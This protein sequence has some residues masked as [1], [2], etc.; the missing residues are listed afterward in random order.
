MKIKKIHA[1]QILDSRGNP[2]IEADVILEDGSLGRAAVPSGA[3]TGKHEALELRDEDSTQHRGKGVLKAIENVNTIISNVLIGSD[4]GSQ[5]NIDQTL[6]SLDGTEN[7][8]RLGANAILAV[9][10]AYAQAVANYK[11]ISFFEYLAQVSG[12]DQQSYIMPVPLMNIINGGKHASFSTDIQEF[13]I[14]PI[15]AK[16]ISDALRMGTDVFHALAEVLSKR[17]YSTNVG[18]EGGYAPLVRKGNEEPLE[19]IS[20]AVK[21]AGLSLGKDIYLALDCAASEFYKNGKYSLKTEKL[22]LSSDEMISWFNKL[23]KSYPIISIEDGLDQEDW[24]GWVNLTKSLGDKI[25]IVGDDI[26]VTKLKFLQRGIDLKAA[27]AILIKLNQ[28]GTLTETIQAVK[29]A[30]E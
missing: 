16:S 30:K 11:K 14:L 25:Q 23:I 7:K 9:S 13:M 20:E 22:T 17:G 18:D 6:I 15:S 27:N 3:S 26:F 8:S 1:R 10:L 5:E 28:V 12:N 24:P 21:V 19:L 2:T 29:L 4:A